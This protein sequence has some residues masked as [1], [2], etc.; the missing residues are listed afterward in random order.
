MMIKILQGAVVLIFVLMAI[1]GVIVLF[2]APESM[3][4]YGKLLGY[5]FPIFL[6]QV[7]PALI[8]SPMTEYIRARAEKVRNQASAA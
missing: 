7:I 6:A 4:A 3:E 5:V 1:M 2:Y 8:G